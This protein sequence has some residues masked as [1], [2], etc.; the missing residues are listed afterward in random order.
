MKGRRNQE[1]STVWFNFFFLCG[2]LKQDC[3]I[4]SSTKGAWI[5][6]ALSEDC[7]ALGNS[8]MLNNKYAYLRASQ[9]IGAQTL[10]ESISS[11]PGCLLSQNYRSLIPLVTSVSLSGLSRI[12][13]QIQRSSGSI[14]HEHI[15]LISF[16]NWG[17][18]KNNNKAFFYTI[19]NKNL[20][21][22]FS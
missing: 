8:V 7:A 20:L 12:D 13:Q 19:F 18:K 4:S 6:M 9:S 10:Q 11:Q 15:N 16:R 17:K 21:M 22:L 2:K 3:S 1:K 5:A 14:K